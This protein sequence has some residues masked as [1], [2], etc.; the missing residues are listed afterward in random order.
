MRFFRYRLT[1]YDPLYYA[2]E[3]L[4]GAHTPAVLHGT[5]INHAITAALCLHPEN[6]PFV[7]SETNGGMDTPRYADSRASSCFYCTPAAISGPPRGWTEMAKGDNEGFLFRVE[8][9]EI[10]KATRLHFL[11]A[12]TTLVGLGL[13]SAD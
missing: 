1:L 12:E 8:R 3:G 6:Q 9:G 10:L 2:R 5:A 7:V 4:L 13:A 11:P